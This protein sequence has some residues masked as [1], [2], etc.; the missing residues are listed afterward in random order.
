[1][2]LPASRHDEVVAKWRHW[3]ELIQPHVIGLHHERRIWREMRDALAERAPDTAG[4]FLS[5]Y[6]RLY[7]DGS[8]M[9]VR[10]LADQS[11]R[12]KTSV[13]LWRLIDDIRKQRDVWTRE[14]Y[15]DLFI[16]D[17]TRAEARRSLRRVAGEEFDE[18]FGD[19]GSGRIDPERLEEDLAMLRSQAGR[20]TDFADRLVAHIDRRGVDELP[21]FAD[22]D[23]AID[24]CGHVFKRYHLLLHA[25]SWLRLEPTIQEDW[26]APFRQ[27]LFDSTPRP[28]SR[29]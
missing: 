29:R 28:R 25:S 1:M 12:D 9:A 18:T 21:T 22:L 3:L 7:V 16:K 4:V 13:S 8:A 23:A 11:K 27:P 14:R 26:K 17:E 20:V 19:D 6:T 24:V 10:R 15:V 2:S 5:H